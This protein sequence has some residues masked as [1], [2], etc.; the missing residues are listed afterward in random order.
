MTDEGQQFSFPDSDIANAAHEFV[1]R[2]SPEFV[3]N[4]SVRSYLFAREIAAAKPLTG[5]ANYDDELVFFACIL[6]DLGA[7]EH[8]NGNERFELDG[9]NAGAEFLRERGMGEPQAPRYG[10]RSCCTPVSVWRRVSASCKLLCTSGFPRTS[11]GW[12]VTCC[13]QN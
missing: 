7:T 10:S 2:V 1:Y 11:W 8:G 9:A 6:H 4:H 13:R 12:P 3:A 5:D